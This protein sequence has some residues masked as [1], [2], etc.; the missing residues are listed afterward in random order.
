M[1]VS[2]RAKRSNPGITRKSHDFFT[3]FFIPKRKKV[4]AR[5]RRDQLL[6][7]RLRHKEGM[8]TVM[9][10][11]DAD[12]VT[13]EEQ[14]AAIRRRLCK[15]LVGFDKGRSQDTQITYL[16]YSLSR[17]DFPVPELVLFAFD[18]PRPQGPTHPNSS[19]FSSPSLRHWCRM[20]KNSCG[21]PP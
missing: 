13:D 14:M 19:P 15:V 10:R 6:T 18:P 8:E 9:S 1:I 12:F 7:W 3:P 20:S 16:N 17:H 21:P 2:L 5:K 4:S 11:A